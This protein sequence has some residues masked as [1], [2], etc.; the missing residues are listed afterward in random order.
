MNHKLIPI[1]LGILLL[2]SI[3]NASL[4][5]SATVD[6]DTLATDEI[7]LL[8]I[9]IFN[10]SDTNAKKVIIKITGDEQIKFFEDAAEKSSIYKTIDSIGSGQGIEA[11]IKIKSLSSKKPTANIYVYYGFEVNPTNAAVTLVQTV[12][13]PQKIVSTMEK[14]NINGKDTIT[15]TFKLTNDSRYPIE[16]VSAEVL[17]PKGFELITEPYFTEKISA[18]QTIDQTFTT[19]APLETRGMQSLTLAYGYFD[20]NVPHYFEKTYEINFQ[21]PDYGFLIIIGIIIL[22]IGVYTFLKKDNKISGGVKGTADK[23]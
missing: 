8:T 2:A 12:D 16:K 17:A 6:K 19:T 21:Q 7:G 13:L 5:I 23:K 3:A 18:G 11:K 20:S 1:I 4:L 22:V 14:K 15:T 10:D 9:K